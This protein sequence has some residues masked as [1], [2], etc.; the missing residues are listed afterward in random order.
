[1]LCAEKEKKV[2]IGITVLR[3]F[4]YP[5]T[6]L[7]GDAWGGGDT[8]CKKLLDMISQFYRDHR[9][10]WLNSLDYSRLLLPMRVIRAECGLNA[11]R[12]KSKV[13]SPFEFELARQRWP[14]SKE[15]QKPDGKP[16]WSAKMY[17]SLDGVEAFGR[18]LHDL[19]QRTREFKLTFDHMTSTRMKEIYAHKKGAALRKA[20]KTPIDKLI[21]ELRGTYAYGALFN[22]LVILNFESAYKPEAP[23]SDDARTRIR[24]DVQQIC[25]SL[26][27][28]SEV[29]T[30]QATHIQG[31]F[32]SWFEDFG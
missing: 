14:A 31:W 6:E 7:T 3:K 10:N 5:V 2:N 26:I 1:M 30:M 13:I 21:N 17:Q 4:K 25:T 18:N 19:Q 22:P 27:Q 23:V 32:E 24:N 12:H 9:G 20:R 16:P 28:S 8:L 15:L 29:N 11:N